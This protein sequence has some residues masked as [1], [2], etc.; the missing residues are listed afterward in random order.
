MTKGKLYYHFLLKLK[1]KISS[2]RTFL[3]DLPKIYINRSLAHV[4]KQTD[5]KV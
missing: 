5:V 1:L 2:K 3:S 4:N